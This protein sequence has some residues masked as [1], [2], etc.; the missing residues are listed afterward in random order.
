MEGMERHLALFLASK[1]IC[2]MEDLAEQSHRRPIG[3]RRYDRRKSRRTHYDGT[4]SL[5]FEGQA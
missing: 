3:Y 1:G 4:Q 2:T 5:W